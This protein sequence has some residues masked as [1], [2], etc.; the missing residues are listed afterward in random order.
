SPSP[1]PPS[2]VIPDAPGLPADWSRRPPSPPRGSPLG[3]PPSRAPAAPIAAPPAPLGCKVSARGCDGRA[4]AQA[5]DQDTA[6]AA[7]VHGRILVRR[8]PIPT[9]RVLRTGPER[10]A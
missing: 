9:A 5:T 4:S 10:Q 6:S 7:L 2:L 8:R 1:A 3:A